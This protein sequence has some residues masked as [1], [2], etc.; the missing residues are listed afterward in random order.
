MVLLVVGDLTHA[1]VLHVFVFAFLDQH[2]EIGCR[3]KQPKWNVFPVVFLKDLVKASP[4][5]TGTLPLPGS[6][7]VY[8]RDA[9]AITA[10]VLGHLEPPIGLGDLVDF[11]VKTNQIVAVSHAKFIHS[12]EVI[13]RK[14]DDTKNGA[15]RNVVSIK[16]LSHDSK[17]KFESP[18]RVFME[19]MA[20]RRLFIDE[21]VLNVKSMHAVF[22]PFQTGDV[23]TVVLNNQFPPFSEDGLFFGVNINL[24]GWGHGIPPLVG[25]FIILTNRLG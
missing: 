7:L 10:T 13:F 4:A 23:V 21:P 6:A 25:R 3:M 15:S 22:H 1:D 8:F 20:Q 9:S 12:V 14:A 18:G 5:H 24:F 16:L 19:N 11:H 2:P 17:T